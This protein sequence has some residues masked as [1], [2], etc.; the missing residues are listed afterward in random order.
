LIT[1]YVNLGLF[2]VLEIKNVLNQ[3]LKLNYSKFFQNFKRF[4]KSVIC[5]DV[6]FQFI[7][8]PS[9]NL[10]VSQVLVVY[11]GHFFF[12]FFVKLKLG[13]DGTYQLLYS[14]V[15]MLSLVVNLSLH[16]VI[17]DLMFLFFPGVLEMHDK[18]NNELSLR[19]R[20]FPIRSQAI[21]TNDVFPLLS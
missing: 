6:I 1:F 19:L 4:D 18:I 20:D 5:L 14:G 3:L 7:N 11:I 12:G 17:Q 8:F 21:R 15:Q 9:L 13:F 2:L 16:I 10:V